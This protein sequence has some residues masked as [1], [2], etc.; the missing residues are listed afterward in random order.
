MKNLLVVLSLLLCAFSADAVDN[1][2]NLMNNDWTRNLLER[3]MAEPAAMQ[4]AVAADE[5]DDETL[6]T[7]DNLDLQYHFKVGDV[8]YRITNHVTQEVE[9]APRH[10]TILI[11]NNASKRFYLDMT[12]TV[13]ETVTVATNHPHYAGKTYT[14]TGVGDQAF[15]LTGVAEV[16]LP[17]TVTYIGD[18]AFFLNEHLKKVT[19]SE[20]LK[21]LGMFVFGASIQL[22]SIELPNTL[23]E[24]PY[25]TFTLCLNLKSVKLPE[26]LKIIPDICFMGCVSLTDI[27]I[28]RSVTHIGAAAFAM[29]SMTEVVLPASLQW[30]G[31]MAFYTQE[32]AGDIGDINIENFD[33]T[34]PAYT[35]VY[36]YAATPP[37]FGGF[38]DESLQ[39]GDITIGV[40]VADCFDQRTYTTAKLYVP[41]G[42]A[43]QYATANEWSK[44]QYIVDGDF[45]PETAVVGFITYTNNVMTGM[46]GFVFPAGEIQ[47][48]IITEYTSEGYAVDK[49]RY[50]GEDVKENMVNVDNMYLG[51]VPE[52]LYNITLVELF[53]NQANSDN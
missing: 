37:A 1:H 25:G 33:G 19:L 39:N 38:L 27:E 43:E 15:F 50:N 24:I 12:I 13:P 16:H 35:D 8:Y 2:A 30:L 14:V 26:T 40:E 44:F 22:E 46:I 47:S 51:T 20:N 42:C 3:M 4:R 18:N 36:C 6:I 10:N 7:D 49:I 48:G 41:E 21:S 53:V 9:V 34:L 31:Y 45:E 52:P 28:P 17:N 32:D 11:G 5:V 29:T 23:S